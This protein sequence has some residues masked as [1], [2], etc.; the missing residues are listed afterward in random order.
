MTSDVLG[1][2][3]HSG[4]EVLPYNCPLLGT[5]FALVT[6]C[7]WCM[8]LLCS[9]LSNCLLYQEKE[10]LGEGES[11]GQLGQSS[12][13]RPTGDGDREACFLNQGMIFSTD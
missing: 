6:F 11:S 5:D 12:F 4:G 1:G 3:G 13:H 9:C 10:G 8:F 7:T 2:Q